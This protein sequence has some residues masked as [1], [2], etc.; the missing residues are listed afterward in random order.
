MRRVPPRG[1]FPA[2]A[3]TRS[4]IIVR[5]VPSICKPPF[6]FIVRRYFYQKAPKHAERAAGKTPAARRSVRYSASSALRPASSITA[7]PRLCALA[8]LPPASSPATT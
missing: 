6:L 5:F 7:T 1:R 3:R 8:S 4:S 2:A